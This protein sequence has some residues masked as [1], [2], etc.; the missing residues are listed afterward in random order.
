MSDTT[1]DRRRTKRFGGHDHGIIS[2]RVRPG[3]EVSVLDVSAGGAL[4]EGACRLMPGT[5][6]ELQL[7]TDRERA[8]ITGRVLRCAVARLR[9]TSVC[10]RGAIGFE[11]HLAWYVDTEH[12]GRAFPSRTRFG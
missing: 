1:P 5:V 4:V 11:R 9:S 3:H 8:A 6:V 2:A 10:Y 7:E 12:V